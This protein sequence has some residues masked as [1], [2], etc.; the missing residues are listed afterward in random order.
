MSATFIA[1]YSGHC[2]QG[3]HHFAEGDTI[4][5]DADDN[6][7]CGDC[8]TGISTEANRK[9]AYEAADPCPSCFLVG[10]C[11]CGTP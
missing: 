9:A 5:Y 4:G 8:L 7:I 2:V 10:P 3:D 1:R 11:D 6:L